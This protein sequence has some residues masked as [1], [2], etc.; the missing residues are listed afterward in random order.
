M[1]A[2]RRQRKLC[3]VLPI[4]RC[5]IVLAAVLSAGLALAEPIRALITERIVTD[6]VS[7]L[8][9]SGF[10]PVAYFTDR[11]ALPGKGTF[12]Q[13][14]AGAPWRFRNP[15]NQA[16]FAA[17]PEV[18]MPRFGGYDPVGIARGVAVAGNPQL[19]LISGERLYLFYTPE[20]RSQFAG[21]PERMIDAA[22]QQWPA[23]RRQLVP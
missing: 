22:E 4:P 9:I 5:A 21:D 2:A 1:T 18:Y 13:V 11:A 19:W 14:V 17:D 12:E 7:G 6:P 10:D 23:V 8:A 16:A 20:A 15:G 3:S